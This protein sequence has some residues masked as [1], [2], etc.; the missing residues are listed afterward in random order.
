[1]PRLSE[2]ETPFLSQPHDDVE[3]HS[4]VSKGASVYFATPLKV[5]TAIF[6][7]A[8]IVAFGFLI[9]SLIGVKT[10]PF[11]YTYRTVPA[12]RDLIIVVCLPLYVF[13]TPFLLDIINTQ[14]LTAF[15]GR[16]GCLPLDSYNLHLLPNSIQPRTQ[17]HFLN[18][19]L[20]LLN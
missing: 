11:Q 6:S 2:E 8:S 18:R 20:S 10:G 15:L 17:H 1:M 12:L 9:V 4:S 5:L 13:H 16:C 3:T 7:I 14:K 19:G